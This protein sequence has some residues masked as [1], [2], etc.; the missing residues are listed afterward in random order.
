MCVCFA[1]ICYNTYV[2]IDGLRIAEQI[3]IKLKSEINQ[4]PAQL[5]KPRLVIIL[6]GNDPASL[7]FIRQK[8]KFGEK[9]GVEVYLKR[10][11]DSVNPQKLTGEIVSLANDPLN[12]GLI[13]QRP[14]PPQLNVNQLNALIPTVKDID[15]FLSDSAHLP[16]VGLA[17]LEILKSVYSKFELQNN[18]MAWLKQQ[19]I[20]LLG[21]GQTAGKPIH[22]TLISFGIN[23]EI[24]RSQT[25]DRAQILKSADIIIAA[26]GKPNILK[27][28]EIKQGTTVL[29]VGL[30]YLNGKAMGDFEIDEIDRVAKFY[31]PTPGGVGPVNV[32]CLYQ[33]LFSAYKKLHYPEVSS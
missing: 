13:I 29:G 3:L 30:S 27:A 33:N 11:P 7:S 1:I 17:V 14:L 26:V 2:K 6:V 5:P 19:K 15:G 24:I 31:T 10:Y 21:F 25:P 9:L 4:I 8:I 23:P 18:F 28:D 20:V 16:P 22:K 32:A 12:H